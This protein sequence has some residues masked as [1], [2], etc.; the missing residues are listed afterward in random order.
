MVSAPATNCTSVHARPAS[1]S[2]AFIACTPYSTKLWPHLPQGCMP[3]PRTAMS[4]LISS[5]RGGRPAPH[6]I[7]VVVVLVQ[8]LDDEPHLHP[9]RE[10]RGIDAIRQLAQDHHL[11][12]R[13]LH[14]A[15]GVGNE[16]IG[17]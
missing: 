6:Q 9:D 11:L 2:A 16:R 12:G 3:T 17:R 8:R 13:E 7:L 5:L 14:G 15:N 4:S 10:P 1:T